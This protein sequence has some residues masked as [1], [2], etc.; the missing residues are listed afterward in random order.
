MSPPVTKESINAAEARFGTPLPTPLRR[1]YRTLG[2]ATLRWCFRSSLDEQKRRRITKV[3]SNTIP[4]YGLFGGAIDIASLEDM[5]F[6][7]EHTPLQIEPDGEF[8]FDGTV[9]SDNEFC[10]MIRHFDTVDEVYAMS[11]I[12][13]P[14][15]T[16]WKM[17]LL[18]DYWI[19]Y[20]SSRVTYLEDY[21]RYIIAT[22]GL[23]DAREELFSEYRGDRRE[24]L[25]YDPGLAAAQ[26]P[27]ILSAG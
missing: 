20:D 21:L 23:V 5:L 6:H 15:Q 10:R 24:P 4:E 19:E 14:D 17:M 2:R 27:T 13:Q 26:V 7:E 22:W 1:L 18:G 16:D 12:V 8:D 25:R 3:P 11:F 9:Y